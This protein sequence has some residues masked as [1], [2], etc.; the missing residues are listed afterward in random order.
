MS[1]NLKIKKSEPGGTNLPVQLK[2]LHKKIST[3]VSKLDECIKGIDKADDEARK[4]KVQAISSELYNLEESLHD[5]NLGIDEV[6]GDDLLNLNEKEVLE[7]FENL[8]VIPALID[9]LEKNLKNFHKTYYDKTIDNDLKL[10][11]F[12][13]LDRNWK[14]V[15]KN[16]M[17]V[18]NNLNGLIQ[19]IAV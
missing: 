13:D 8:E 18:L 16:V 10:I 12:G 7:Q 17:R 4:V 15:N 14:S 9:D 2:K 3:S 6:L 11:S 19:K 1:K 5:L